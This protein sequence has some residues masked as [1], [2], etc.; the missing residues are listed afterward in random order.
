MNGRSKV[1]I[2]WL[3]LLAG[4][5]LRESEKRISQMRRRAEDRDDRAGVNLLLR[6]LSL[7]VKQTEMLINERLRL[8]EGFRGRARQLEFDTVR[9]AIVQLE[10]ALSTCQTLVAP[11]ERD[12]AALIQPYVRLAKSLT[13]DDGTELIFES[14]EL[15]EYEVWADVFEE[16]REILEMVAPSLELRIENLPPFALITY[17]GRADSETLM[18]AVIAHEVIH[19][20]LVQKSEEGTDQ[21]SEVF[22]RKLHERYGKEEAETAKDRNRKLARWLNECLADSLALRVIGPAYFLGLAEYLLPTH[23]S[24]ASVGPLDDSHPPPA[25]RLQRL[26]LDAGRFF[27]DRGGS[28]GEAAKAFTQFLGLVPASIEPGSDDE[29]EELELLEEMVGEIDFEAL[30]GEAT[31]PVDRF[32]RDLPLVWAKLAQDVAPVERVKGRRV[33]GKRAE[34]KAPVLNGDPDLAAP[35]TDWSQS[36]D[37]RSILNGGYLHYLRKSLMAPRGRDA[38]D[39]RRDR[40]QAN[41]LVRGS[42]ELSELHRRMIEL[43]DQFGT[44][45]PIEAGA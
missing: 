18:H 2:E 9:T 45:G 21:V 16:A 29:R 35:E 4:Q 25:W 39:L 27:A 1:E 10:G 31:Y 8:A 38:D 17:P 20:A 24:A 26:R 37:W 12:V 43:R 19:L 36:V 14:G 40:L 7:V 13:G 44:L 41:S 5:R 28:R 6:T 32:R 11:P 15:F 30:A 33:E 3:R 22:V 42:I 34:D 23:I